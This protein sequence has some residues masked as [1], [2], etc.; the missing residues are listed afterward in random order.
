MTAADSVSGFIRVSFDPPLSNLN[1]NDFPAWLEGRGGDADGRMLVTGAGVDRHSLTARTPHS[2]LP[3]I[4]RYRCARD[5][6]QRPKRAAAS[7]D[8][9]ARRFDSGASFNARIHHVC[10]NWLSV[11]RPH[12][13]GHISPPSRPRG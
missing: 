5:T 13:V 2:R 6:G 4:V 1:S 3:G 11:G 9:G 12:G 8:P 10:R 7:T